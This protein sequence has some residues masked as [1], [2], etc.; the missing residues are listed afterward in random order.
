MLSLFRD[1]AKTIDFDDAASMARLKE[2]ARQALEA[3][4]GETLPEKL[5]E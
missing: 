2:Y 5:P 4:I 3:F 1:M